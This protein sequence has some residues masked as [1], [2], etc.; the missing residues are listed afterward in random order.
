MQF[1]LPEVCVHQLNFTRHHNSLVS[2]ERV[3]SAITTINRQVVTL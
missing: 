1:I 3:L 2:R